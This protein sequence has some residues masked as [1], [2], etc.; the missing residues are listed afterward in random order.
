VAGRVLGGG[1][2]LAIGAGFAGGHEHRVVA[3][4]VAPRGGQTRV[5]SARP[6][7]VRIS[8]SARRATARR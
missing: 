7:Q 1:V 2:D 3:E 6:S 4:A 8:P 5:P